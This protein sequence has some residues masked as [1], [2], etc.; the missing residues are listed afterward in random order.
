MYSISSRGR[1]RRFGAIK[2]RSS[3]DKSWHSARGGEVNLCELEQ[4]GKKSNTL[5]S[6]EQR[7]SETVERSDMV[8]DEREVH[9]GTYSYRLHLITYRSR[10]SDI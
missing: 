7:R 1:V 9:R 8:I 6:S 3:T 10:V 4:E 5:E 2:L